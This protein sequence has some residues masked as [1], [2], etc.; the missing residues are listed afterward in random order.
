MSRDAQPAPSLDASQLPSDVATCH[1]LIQEL[2]TTVNEMHRRNQ[3]LE[4]RV[5]QLCRHQYGPRSERDPNQPR[6]FEEPADGSSEVSAGQNGD[7]STIDVPAHRRQ[8][9]PGRNPIPDHLPRRRLDHELSETDR[10][11]PDCG[12]LRRRI[13][14]EVSEQLDY[15][16]ASLFVW[17][18][19]QAKYACK[20]CEGHVVLA[21]KPRQPIEKS[22]AGPG[23][24]AHVIVSKYAD[25]HPLN[26]QNKILKRNGVDIARSTQCGW[27]ADI[28][29]LLVPIHERMGELIRK[30]RCVQTDDTPNPVLEKGRGRTKTGRFWVYRGDHRYPY[31]VFDYTPDRSR[32]GP[33]RWLKHY[34]GYLQADAYSVYDQLF[35][36]GT[37]AGALIEVA[38]WM[39][40][41]RYFYNA[42]ESAPGLAQTAMAWIGQLYA[43]EKRAR[44]LEP[45]QRK[46]LR[47]DEAKPILRTFGKWLKQQHDRVLPKDP[48]G[49]AVNYAL[50]NWRALNRYVY[51]GELSI[52]NG[53][54]ERDIRP[55]KVGAHNWLFA[56][57]DAGGRTAAIHFS[58][59]RTCERHGIDPFA[60]YRD[61]LT[62]LPDHPINQIDE[63]L[64]DRWQPMNA[65]T[66]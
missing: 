61:V 7:E 37:E 64:P 9:R 24:L 38:C 42:R 4:H 56:G 58:I 63:L 39:H 47:K 2:C 31:T 16:P 53:A 45:H 35:I 10:A 3:Q 52:D 43:I 8:R 18:H 49:K 32:D 36:E 55:I 12:E 23:L 1:Q 14:E 13:G 66:H 41:R 34:S 65:T 22:L 51:D 20:A 27:C 26:R 11:C 40:G 29:K 5:E 15:I 62:R 48:I 6:L 60:Y 17:Q 46:A 50:S 21:E 59:I 28:A 25:H 33:T 30:S 19:V 44:D 57:S 54:S